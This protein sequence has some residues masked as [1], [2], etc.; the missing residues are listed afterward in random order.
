MTG[1]RRGCG[2]VPL[3][4]VGAGLGLLL[5]G[6]SAILTPALR[7]SMDERLEY[8]ERAVAQSR[9]ELHKLAE[10]SM[11]NEQRWAESLPEEHQADTLEGVRK[12]HAERDR[13]LA[14]LDRAE[15]LIG[16][17]RSDLSGGW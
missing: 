2:C 8:S 14:Q 15:Q 4:V 10:I 16:T 6:C 12:R 3:L 17:A 11:R 13:F 9:Q 7:T 5:S 1:F